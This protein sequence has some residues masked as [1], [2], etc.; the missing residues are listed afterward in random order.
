M[1]LIAII[2]ENVQVKG[3]LEYL[4]IVKNAIN[5]KKRMNHEI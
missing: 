4:F 3:L 5:L 2:S 1:I